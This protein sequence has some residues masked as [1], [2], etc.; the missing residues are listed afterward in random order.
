[1]T[2]KDSDDKRT[3]DTGSLLPTMRK[4][5]NR[6]LRACAW[7]YASYCSRIECTTS[8]ITGAKRVTT[9]RLVTPLAGILS[10]AQYSRTR[11][12]P[13]N[14]PPEWHRWLQLNEY[15]ALHLDIQQYS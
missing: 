3:R 4:G 2:D 11:A 12:A 6:H 8:T 10:D 13:K 7:G 5:Q 14:K 15:T 1:M 9:L